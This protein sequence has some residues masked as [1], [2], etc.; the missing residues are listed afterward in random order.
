MGVDPYGDDPISNITPFTRLR[1]AD[2]LLLLL[3]DGKR[4]LGV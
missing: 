4:V 1:F 3:I 2:E